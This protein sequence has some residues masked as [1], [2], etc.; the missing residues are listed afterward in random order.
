MIK[1]RKLFKLILMIFLAV[2]GL[3]F[4]AAAVYGILNNEPMTIPGSHRWQTSV[5]CGI[6][7]VWCGIAIKKLY[8]SWYD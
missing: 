5:Y 2:A 8:D 3:V 6:L 1:L 7:V 4:T